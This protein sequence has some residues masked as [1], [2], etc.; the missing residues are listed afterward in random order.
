MTKRDIRDYLQDILD[1]IAIAEKF[2][3]GM[4]FDEFQ[5]DE[6][7]IFA[8]IRAIEVIGEATKQIPI[9]LREK[10]PDILW[11]GIV[12]MRN[13]LIHVYFGVKLKVLWDTTQEDL[14]QLRPV[15]Q[16]MLDNLD[17]PDSFL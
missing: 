17:A 9:P 2:V 14:P 1:H 16:S 6:K 7:T 12:G 8:L 3:D 10:Y 4:T 11:Q 15:I 5:D 13:R